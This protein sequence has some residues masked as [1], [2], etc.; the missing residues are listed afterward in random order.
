[1]TCVRV[2][3]PKTRF[4]RLRERGKKRDP[5][6]LEEFKEP[7]RSEEA[8]FE[9]GRAIKQADVVI[10]NDTDLK[11]LHRRIERSLLWDWLCSTEA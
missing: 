9:I 4:K 5:L 11:A 8:Q 7:E 10:A 1:M 2:G 3:D 6:T